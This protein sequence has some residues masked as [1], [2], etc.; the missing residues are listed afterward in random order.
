[1]D[2]GDV[3]PVEVDDGH[4]FASLQVPDDLGEGAQVAVLGLQGAG[5]R[6]A[7]HRSV[8]RRR[9]DVVRRR[10]RRT[11]LDVDLVA[12]CSSNQMIK[13]ILYYLDI[14]IIMK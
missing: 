2:V 11:V 14:I 3:T 8:Q 6:H 1:M 4:T 5:Q 13:I 12:C 9:H 7:A 10:F